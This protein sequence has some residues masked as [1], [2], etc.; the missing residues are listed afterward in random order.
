MLL[1]F[2]SSLALPRRIIAH[3]FFVFTSTPPADRTGLPAIALGVFHRAVAS[4]KAFSTG[5]VAQFFFFGEVVAM[6][7]HRYSRSGEK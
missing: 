7:N 5:D 1:S 4:G 3:V 6:L 2:L